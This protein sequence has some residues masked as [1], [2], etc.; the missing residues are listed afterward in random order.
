MKALCIFCIA[1]K[2]SAKYRKSFAVVTESEIFS[3]YHVNSQ[4]HLLS[5]IRRVVKV[6]QILR[7]A[8]KVTRLHEYVLSVGKT[9]KIFTILV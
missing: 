2:M 7:A 1:A 6:S 9:V 3:P 4:S 5:N 8:S